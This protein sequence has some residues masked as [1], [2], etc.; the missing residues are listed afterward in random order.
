M[1]PIGKCCSYYCA[2]L[3]LFGILVFLILILLEA[4]GH[5]WLLYKQGS[6]DPEVIDR[7]IVGLAIASFIYLLFFFIF[8]VFIWRD[9]AK[10]ARYAAIQA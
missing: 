6:S 7:K 1:G 8:V 4:S 3:M 9:N 10:K 2:V 5:K